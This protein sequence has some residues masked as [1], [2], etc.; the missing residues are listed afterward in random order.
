MDQNDFIEAVAEQVPR[1]ACRSCGKTF[2]VSSAGMFQEVTC[3]GCGAEQTVPA[4]LGHFLLLKP[5]GRGGMAAVL[6]A[7]DE[8]LGRFVA[9]KVM[10]AEL[11]A[12][13]KFVES[14]L[15]EARAAA[16]LNHRHVVQIYSVNV[17]KGRPY[18]VMELLDGGRLD[19]MIAKGGPIGEQRALEIGA[20]VAQGLAAAAEIGLVHGDIKP[21]NILFDRNG[22]AKVADFGLARFQ[23]QRKI[24]KGEIWGTPYYIAPEKVRS[25]KEDQR[26]DIYS[27]GATLYHA[28][29]GKPPFE[30]ETATDVV[31]ARLK[32]PPLSLRDIQ[33]GIHPA[34]AAL[35]GRMLEPDP[36][37]RYPTYASLL[38]DLND[39]LREV[40]QRKAPP[41]PARRRRVW[42]W[43]LL[44]ALCAAGAAAFW[45]VSRLRNRTPPPPPAPDTGAAAAVTNAAPE[46]AEPPAE[47][48]EPPEPAVAGPLPVQ[49]FAAAE[50]EGLAAAFLLTAQ[51]RRVLAEE[52]MLDLEEALPPGHAGRPWLAWVY[53]VPPWLERD[54]PEVERRLRNLDE[55]VYEPQPDGTPNPALLPQA[56]GRVLLGRPFA[57]PAAKAGE[58]WPAWFTDLADFVRGFDALAK[59]EAGEAKACWTRYLAAGGG[60]PAWPYAFQ[61]VASNYLRRAEQWDRLREGVTNRVAKGQGQAA[62]GE[63][64]RRAADAAWAVWKG[65]IE[66]A[67]A[68]ARAAQ[69][70]HLAQIDAEKAR[71][72]EGLRR[73]KVQAELDALDAV[74]EPLGAAVAR[75]EFARAAEVLGA[76]PAP[77]TREAAEVLALMRRAVERMEV[78]F[79]FLGES[80]AGRPFSQGRRELGGAAV[81]ATARGVTVALP[82]GVGNVEKT[83]D[84]VNPRLFAQMV[85]FYLQ[86]A[87]VPAEE[88]ATVSLALA[89]YLYYSGAVRPAAE[90]AAAAVRADPAIETEVRR[91]MPG[92]L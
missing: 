35:I 61:P 47:P 80:M 72:A 83:W 6:Q 64:E 87:S 88:R 1:L 59:G 43:F 90:Y 44:L 16:Q 74:R 65:E 24:K 37:R 50:Q 67:L 21:A 41:A 48:A 18:I 10:R 84:Q 79:G 2:D 25:Q 81:G 62:I 78:L 60:E 33:P 27:L 38:S 42:P 55:A 28:L 85:A 86:P 76:L 77:E 31:L 58:S 49:P 69:E 34:T 40:R 22:S 30:G 66:T 13:E 56:L 29:G 8:N 52:K 20:E 32:E 70:A 73:E 36:F 91:H 14:F 17:M 39:A 7:Y 68:G 75:K 3:P 57:A 82:G 11:H 4:R 63:L 26:S 89:L 12:D 9:I 15:R 71:E 54:A 53:A 51:G 23:T 19:E 45:A 46:P 5:L 92:L